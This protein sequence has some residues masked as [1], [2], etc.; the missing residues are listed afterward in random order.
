VIVAVLVQ[1]MVRAPP[2]A[3]STLAVAH[4]ASLNTDSLDLA[5]ITPDLS[6][7]LDCDVG[8]VVASIR[9]TLLRE[10]WK[11]VLCENGDYN[12]SE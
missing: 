3:H 10:R 11:S 6:N 1:V 7:A 2:A 8:V 4:T 9:G 12:R 5:I